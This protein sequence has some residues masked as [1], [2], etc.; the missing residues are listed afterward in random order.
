MKFLIDKEIN[1]SEQDFLHTKDYAET[2]KQVILNSPNNESFCIGLFGEWGSGK[3]SIVNTV[4]SELEKNQNKKIKFITYDAWK[5]ANDSFRRMFLLK[6]K[7]ELNFKKK[8]LFDSFYQNKNTDKSIEQKPNWFFLGLTAI[9]FIVGL[10]LISNIKNVEN[11]V[12]TGLVFS[13][14]GILVNVFGKAFKDYKFTVSTPMKFA[15]EQFEECFEEMATTALKNDTVIKKVLKWIE[16][17]LGNNPSVSGL[18]KLVIVFDNIDRTHK[19]LAY[20][21]LTNTKNFLGKIPNII[22]LLP[23]DDASLKRHILNS[24]A[25]SKEAEEFLRKFFNVTFRIKPFR[26]IE[27]YDFTYKLA[28]KSSL[29]LSNITIDVISK[30]YATNPRRIIQFINNLTV[31]LKF[32]EGKFGADFIKENESAIC[33]L[34]II[35]EEWQEYFDYIAIN[36]YLLLSPDAKG[37]QILQ[38]NQ[39]LAIFL[40]KIKAVIQDIDTESLFKIISNSNNISSLSEEM[41]KLIEEGDVAKIHGHIESNNIEEQEFENYLYD[42]L[43]KGLNNQLFPTEVRNTFTLIAA[44]NYKKEFR[45]VFHNRVAQISEVRLSNFLLYIE[46]TDS[47]VR[48]GIY[49]KSKGL[50]Y[51]DRY[52]ADLLNQKSNEI[53]LTPF[54]SDLLRS[55]LKLQDESLIGK[56]KNQFEV[57]YKESEMELEEYELS[58][59]KYEILVTDKIISFL[60]GRIDSLMENENISELV[61]AGE[62]TIFSESM[63]KMFFDRLNDLYTPN[64]LR[65]QNQKKLLLLVKNISSILHRQCRNSKSQED[66]A[67]VQL[68]YSNLFNSFSPGPELLSEINNPEDAKTVITFIL[69][70]YKT[71]SAKVETLSQLREIVLISNEYK[72]IFYDFALGISKKYGFALSEYDDLL[73][74]ETNYSSKYLSLLQQILTIKDS[75]GIYISSEDKV[76]GKIEELLNFTTAN[77]EKNVADFLEKNLEDVRL[78]E[79]LL[80]LIP[81][82]KMEKILLLPKKIQELS[83]DTVTQ[84]ESL[85]DFSDNE[86]FLKAIAERGTSSQIEKLVKVIVVKLQKKESIGSGLSVLQSVKELNKTDA[87]IIRSIIDRIPEDGDFKEQIVAAKEK[88]GKVK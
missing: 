11:Q 80:E 73:F 17:K 21:L 3:S 42:K 67:G 13:F 15:P 12:L 55:Y 45:K 10:A 69:D 86:E 63:Y 8:D 76:K 78:K 54:E 23:V 64:I 32:L 62:K 52:I 18:D 4:K 85:F 47:L 48:Y 66:A 37:N 79:T 71:S 38:E 49:L 56:L 5:Y 51:L 31:E 68:F 39:S 43:S 59:E 74:T 28:N 25:D 58:D 83:F 65:S 77:S 9:I 40:Q 46:D 29:E 72:D 60:V 35:K 88:I 2:I 34:L 26:S 7:E 33:T 57:D 41:L 84:N 27:M 75:K 36:P 82:L 19:E 24:K 6:M 14:A 20:E 81:K 30:E 50:Q 44:L 61:Y 53:K 87:K 16:L 1:L 70:V 22:F